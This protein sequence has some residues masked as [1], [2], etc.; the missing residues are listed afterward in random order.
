MNEQAGASPNKYTN[1]ARLWEM[2][3]GV[4]R[5]LEGE[6]EGLQVREVLTRLKMA[7]PPTEC[8]LTLDSSGVLRYDTKVR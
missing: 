4:V 7:L 8:E 3:L 6:P 5:L 2:M 1:K